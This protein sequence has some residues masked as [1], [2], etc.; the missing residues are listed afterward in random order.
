M[1]NYHKFQ[2][3][4]QHPFIISQFLQI[5]SPGTVWLSW[6]FCLGSLNDKIKVFQGCVLYWRLCE[7]PVSKIIQVVSRIVVLTAVGLRSLLFYGYQRRGLYFLK[8]FL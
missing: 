7:E 1:T 8:F 5:R 2:G 4:K 6:F 3:L